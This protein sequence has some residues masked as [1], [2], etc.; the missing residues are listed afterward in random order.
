MGKMAVQGPKSIAS[1]VGTGGTETHRS[2]PGHLVEPELSQDLVLAVL[3][4][5]AIQFLFKEKRPFRV[6]EGG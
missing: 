3:A 1:T 6:Y 5:L 4:V 2:V